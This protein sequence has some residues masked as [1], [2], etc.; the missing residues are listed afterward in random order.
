MASN[1]SLLVRLADALE[2]RRAGWLE[3]LERGLPRDEK[4]QSDYAYAVGYLAAIA[5]IKSDIKDIVTKLEKD[6]GC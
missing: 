2:R 1:K 4:L 6:H 5:E 3:A